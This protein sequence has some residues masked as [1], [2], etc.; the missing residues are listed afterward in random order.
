MKAIEVL[1]RNIDFSKYIGEWV[2]ICEDKVIAHNE[3]V[4]KLE[5]DIASCRRTPKIALIPSDDVLILNE[6]CF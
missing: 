3:D 1:P 6:S 4:R 5:K 2:V